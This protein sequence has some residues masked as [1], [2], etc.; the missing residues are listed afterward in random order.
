MGMFDVTARRTAKR[1]PEGFF[2]W[3]LPRLDPALAFRGWLDARTAPPPPESELTCDALAEF[4]YTDRP[5]EPWI[6]VTEFQTAPRGEDLERLV[7]YMVRFRREHRPPLDPRLKYRVGGVLLNL[8]GPA[9][10]AALAMILPGMPDVG[11]TGR[12]VRMAVHDEDAE[13]TLVRIA[14]GQLNRCVLPW[15]ALMRSGGEPGI[16]E[17]WKRL[18]DLEADTRLRLDYAADALTFA[19]LP[20]VRSVWLKALE[21]WNVKVSQQVLE[22]QAEARVANQQANVIRLLEMRCKA[23][24]PADLAAVIQGTQDM[25]LLVRWFDAAVQASSF[26]EFRAAA[27][28]GK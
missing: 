3:V 15:V 20:D 16:I 9:Q 22:W 26:D 21:G 2:Q 25:A 14:A 24:V 10:P 5:D 17:E 7:E 1:A 8:T 13:A 18:A 27:G 19:D 11:L 4:A 6:I 28:L 12:V 23:A